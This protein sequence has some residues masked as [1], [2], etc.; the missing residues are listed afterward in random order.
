MSDYEDAIES[1]DDVAGAVANGTRL[2][3]R[4]STLNWDL[5]QISLSSEVPGLHEVKDLLESDV[6]SALSEDELAGGCPL[7]STPVDPRLLET[8]VCSYSVVLRVSF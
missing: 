8:E 4:P 7:P 2:R 3:H 1:L 6:S 5:D